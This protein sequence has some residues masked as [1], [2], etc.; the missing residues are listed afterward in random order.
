MDFNQRFERLLDEQDY[1]FALE[2]L[3]F[4][5]H[6]EIEE[7]RYHCE[8]LRLLQAMN[9]EDAF[10]NYYYDIESSISSF[11]LAIQNRISQLVVDLAQ[12]KAQ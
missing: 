9:D 4:A 11:D 3:N 10:Y 5:R 2:L 7:D 12:S 6:N 8:R 1:D